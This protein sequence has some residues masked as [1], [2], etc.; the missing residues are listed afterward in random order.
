MGSSAI[1]DY[2]GC[3]TVPPARERNVIEFSRAVPVLLMTASPDQGHN[4]TDI[5]EPGGEGEAVLA[6]VLF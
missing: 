2:G 6:V 3:L 5:E 1:T 4:W